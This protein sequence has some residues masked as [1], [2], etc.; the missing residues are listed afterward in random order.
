VAN[1]T[2]F[3]KLCLFQN[4]VASFAGLEPR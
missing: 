2:W 3:F 1:V 4:H